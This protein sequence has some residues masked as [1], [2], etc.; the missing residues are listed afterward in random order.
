MLAKLMSRIKSVPKTEF[1]NFLLPAKALTSDK[2]DTEYLALSL[3]LNKVPIWSNDAH[4]KEQS[5]IKIFT[6]K[7]LV[8]YLKSL[9]LDFLTPA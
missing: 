6:T 1:E 8:N 5:A 2:D 7:E 3:A 4:F 9:G